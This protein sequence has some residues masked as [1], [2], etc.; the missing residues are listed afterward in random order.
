MDAHSTLWE[1]MPVAIARCSDVFLGGAGAAHRLPAAPS[2]RPSRS[3][4]LSW[5]Y[6]I[7]PKC[8]TVGAAPCSIYALH[9]RRL[10]RHVTQ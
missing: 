4:S 3:R 10:F 2:R 1:Q 5:R 6:G 9:A 8:A 7:S